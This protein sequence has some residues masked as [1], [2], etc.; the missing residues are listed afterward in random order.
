GAPRDCAPAM[1]RPLFPVIGADHR[2]CPS[3]LR[4]SGPCPT[5]PPDGVRNTSPG[6]VLVAAFLI[7]NLGG[8][9]SGRLTKCIESSGGLVFDGFG[10]G[11]G[12]V[13]TG[14]GRPTSNVNAPFAPAPRTFSAVRTVTRSPG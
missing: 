6:A 11:V 10:T 13:F 2:G 9:R 1:P 4:M 5:V 3:S 14:A 12:G 7:V 8:V